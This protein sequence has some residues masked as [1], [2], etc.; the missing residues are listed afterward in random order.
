MQ[1][2]VATTIHLI[3]NHRQNLEI[4]LQARSDN[5]KFMLP[6]KLQLTRVPDLEHPEISRIKPN[7]KIYLSMNN[8]LPGTR[9]TYNHFNANE[10]MHRGDPAIYDKT[11]TINKL[12]EEKTLIVGPFGD[13]QL[14]KFQRYPNSIY[15]RIE[16]N[17]DESIVFPSLE[18]MP[19]MTATKV[20]DTDK[21]EEATKTLLDEEEAQR[22]SMQ[23][24]QQLNAVYVD[25]CIERDNAKFRR[26]QKL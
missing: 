22:E 6:I 1:T 17:L 24:N 8:I 25:Y 23:I 16:S 21:Y 19:F 26:L 9:T 3:P 11:I 4:D 15:I 10:K 18:V 13:E 2:N 20:V 14:R 12:E 7:L 5:D